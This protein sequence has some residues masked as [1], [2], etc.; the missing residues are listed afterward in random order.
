VRQPESPA[1]NPAIPEEALDLRRMCV[2]ADVEVFRFPAKQEIANAA[3]DEIGDVLR[4]VK[5]IEDAKSVRVDVSA[6]NT[7]IR[8]RDDNGLGHEPPL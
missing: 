5:S 8:S 2:G 7:V 4:F 3:A 1:D 6:R